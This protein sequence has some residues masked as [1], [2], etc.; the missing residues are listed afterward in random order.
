MEHEEWRKRYTIRLSQL[1]LFTL[2][3]LHNRIRI[4]GRA[5]S[6]IVCGTWMVPIVVRALCTHSNS[7]PSSASSKAIVASAA[8]SRPDRIYRWCSQHIRRRHRIIHQHNH[9][10]VSESPW[11][12]TIHPD[13][14]YMPIYCSYCSGLHADTCSCLLS[15]WIQNKTRPSTCKWKIRT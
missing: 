7:I 1:D 9:R 10:D 3:R 2:R 12:R 13:L 11:C 6:P 8:G 5:F 14:S 15:R 4:E